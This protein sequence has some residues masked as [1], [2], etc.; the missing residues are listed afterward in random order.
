MDTTIDKLVAI[1]GEANV[2]SGDE[3]SS[4]PI[5]SL[6]ASPLDAALLVRPSTTE[7]VSAVLKVC[8]DANLPVVTQGGLTGLCGGDNTSRRDVILSMQRMTNIESVDPQGNTMTVQAGCQLEQVQIAAANADRHFALDLGARGS[9]TIGGNIA[10]NAG[11]LSVL[12]Y[13]MMREQVLGLEVVLADGTV[14]SSLNHMLKNNAGYDLKQWFIGSEGTLG[15]VTRAVLRL[16]PASHSM[17]TALFAFDRF[18]QVTDT[19]NTLSSSLGGQLTAF[20]VIWNNFYR[21]S[22]SDK[23]PPCAPPLDDHYPLYAI[24][25]S[26]GNKT[27]QDALAF[28]QA[29]ELAA[30]AGSISDAVVA[31]SHTQ[32][33]QIWEIRENVGSA[34]IDDPTF[35]YDISLPIS[36]MERYVKDL[37]STLI[38]RWPQMKFF[39]FG[40]LADGNLH[41]QLSPM[42]SDNSDD[43]ASNTQ[44]HHQVNQLVYQP[45]TELGGSI[46]AEHG[47]GTKK[48]P[49]L[50][51]CRSDTEIS[52]M[53]TIKQALD[54]KGLLN[55]GK[56]FD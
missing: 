31:Q 6:D 39:C 27:E 34:M 38:S 16:R 11:G 1:V 15:I 10:T 51:M 2:L 50:S 54:P 46:S 8:F 53:R 13:G 40:H 43:D 17:Q 55:P 48:K 47:I 56:V 14:M 12:R 33:R 18:E 21:V 52:M 5:N 3:L 49:Y 42:Q 37:E 4:R 25:E 35:L 19:L 30:E 29:I 28:Q 44:L 24:A 20:E 36:T 41:L 45:L 22:T 7:E 32:R 9:C 23:R 26:S